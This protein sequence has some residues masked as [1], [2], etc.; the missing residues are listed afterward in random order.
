MQSRLQA[1]EGRLQNF[2]AHPISARCHPA[3]SRSER[4]IEMK[5]R[6]EIPQAT[7]TSRRDTRFQSSPNEAPDGPANLSPQDANPATAS[8][9]L[10]RAHWR[11][12]LVRVIYPP[13]PSKPC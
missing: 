3:K 4:A 7:S 6:A 11:R 10:A 13:L 1:A 8:L 9:V 12:L 2:R 5:S